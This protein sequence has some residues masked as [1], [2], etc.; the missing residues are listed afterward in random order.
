MSL[1]AFS[2]GFL[3]SAGENVKERNKEVR[4]AAIKEFERLQKEAME[5]NEKI[6][7]KRDELKST[8]SVLASYKGKNNSGFTQGQVISLLQ[9]PAVAKR[10]QSELEKYSGNLDQID[11]AKLYQVS[12]GQDENEDVEGFIKRYTTL[13]SA[14]EAPEAPEGPLADEQ[15]AA[16]R[17]AFGLPSRAYEQAQTDFERATGRRVAD[18]RAQAQGAPRMPEAPV[19]RVDFGQLRKPETNQNIRDRLRDNIAN[20]EDL[21]SPNNKELLSKLS[22]ASQIKS[23]FGD[24]DSDKPRTAAQIRQV[25]QDSMRVGVDPFILKGVVRY[26]ERAQDYVP[27]TGNPE[28][29]KQFMQHKNEVVRNQAVSMGILDRKGNILG[30]RNAEDALLPYANI[31]NGKIV[32]WKEGQTSESEGAPTTPAQDR[33]PTRQNAANLETEKAN[34]YAAIAAAA[35]NPKAI[36]NIKRAFKQRTGQDLP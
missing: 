27:I 14:P 9:N 19:G 35:N 21:K 17:G 34:A 3:K 23:Q 12:R 25:F 24:E 16:T 11:F 4:D 28:D 7:T 20:G 22:A 31:K 13:P 6:Q 8:A 1:L 26:D 5:Q 32:S 15:R 33:A 36:A 18:V 30:G 10:V 2:A 29:I